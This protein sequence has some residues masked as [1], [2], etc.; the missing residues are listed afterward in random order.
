M[1]RALRTSQSLAVNLDGDPSGTASGAIL[2]QR[3][4]ED[5]QTSRDNKDG[6]D[7]CSTYPQLLLDVIPAVL[8]RLAPGPASLLMLQAMSPGPLSDA[9]IALFNLFPT[10]SSVASSSS[11]AAVPPGLK[12]VA[13][14]PCGL[15]LE[16]CALY[17][18]C[19]LHFH[20][21]SRRHQVSLLSMSTL[22]GQIYHFYTG[23]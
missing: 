11:S 21:L 3:L 8:E 22:Y 17:D 5:T 4:P 20:L 16:M 15:S 13:Q 6:C 12:S 19:L 7:S 9:E 1:G 23:A 10:P 18:H 14:H 2:P